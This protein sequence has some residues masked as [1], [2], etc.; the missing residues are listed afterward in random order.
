V[1]MVEGDFAGVQFNWINIVGGEFDGVALGVFNQ[2]D[3][4]TGSAAGFMAGLVN[5]TDTFEGLQ[6]G[7]VN[8]TQHLNGLQIGIINIVEQKGSLPILPIVNWS[9]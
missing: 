4:E 6:L 9:F 8:H 2:A 1:G 3:S 7:L 5:V